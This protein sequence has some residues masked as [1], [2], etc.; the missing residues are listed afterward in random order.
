MTQYF[1][2][3]PIRPPSEARSLLIRL[4]RNCPWNKCAFCG[5]Y[6]DLKFALRPPREVIDDINAVAAIVGQ[7]QELSQEQGEGGLISERILQR[8]WDSYPAYGDRHRSVALWLYY[9]GE[10]LF[11]QDADSLIMK[12]PD[13]ASILRHIGQTFPFVRRITTYCRSKTAA[14]KSLADLQLLAEAGLSRIHIGLESGCDPLLKFIRKG[15]TAAEHVTAGSKIKAAGLSLSEYVIPGLGGERWTEEH[16]RETAEVINAINPNFIRL[17]S[18]HLSRGTALLEMMEQGE[19]VPLDDDAVVREIRN[20]LSRLEGITSTIVSDHALNLL[21][22]VQGRL[23][24]EKDKILALID[25]Y[26][27][28]SHR[29]RLIFRL[30][31]RRGLY[32]RL[33]DLHNE[34]TYR[35]LEELVDQYEKREKG[36]LEKHLCQ[37]MHNFI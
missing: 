2:Q 28:L 7:L 20:F 35:G 13:V 29:K 33:E 5:T 21:E 17:R 14:H 16:A 25:R 15:A 37:I 34:A 11:L 9:G 6:R 24:E 12:A 26:L 22:E 31:R 19:F 1:E 32:R 8:V 3:G 30:G 36:A 23:P 27:A 4:T 18:L 10:S